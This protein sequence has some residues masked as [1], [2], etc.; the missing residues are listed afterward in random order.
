MNYYEYFVGWRYLRA[1]PFQTVMST[2]GIVL[3]IWLVIVVISGFRGFQDTIRDRLL[4]S[5]PHLT[6]LEGLARFSDYESVIR[7]LEEIPN[8]VAVTP[9]I[10]SD[11]LIQN[12]KEKR[13]RFGIRVYGVDPERAPKV[14]RLDRYISGGLRFD[15]PEIIAM[16][17]AKLPEGDTVQG[18]IILGS[19]LARRLNVSIGDPVLLYSDFRQRGQ[20]IYPIIRN[21]VVV[22]LYTSGLKE[23]DSSV[24]YVSLD[25]A[26]ALFGLE[27]TITHIEIRTTSLEEADRVKKAVLDRFG[28]EFRPITWKEL[29]GEFFVWLELEERLSFAVLAL[30]VIVAGFSIAITLVMLVREKTREIGILKAMGASNQSVLRIFVL[31]GTIVGVLGVIIG[32]VLALITSYVLEYWLRIPLPGDVYQ[33]D[34][35]HM[36]VSWVYVTLI[37][38]ITILVCWLATIY[39]ALRAAKLRPVDALR[40]E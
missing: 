8:V 11:A 10:M 35:V 30:S 29:R 28:A 38:V 34:Q 7:D 24:A 39:P 23:I 12:R 15:L 3:G 21:L 2:L 31:H 5:E 18:G 33:V 22:G 1:K 25:V 40:M 4:G 6:L 20:A 19:W 32:T 13:R 9:A 14:T 16:G 27:G 36:K 26:Q 37:N 17:K